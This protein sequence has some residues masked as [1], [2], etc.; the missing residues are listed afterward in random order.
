M[1]LAFE[2]EFIWFSVF[3]LLIIGYC[4]LDGFDL[5]VGMLHLF[6]S[7]DHERRLMLNSIGPVWD[8]NEVWLVTAGG[9]LL[10]GF[11]DVYATVFSAFYL[12]LMALLAALIFRA[13]AIEFRSKQPMAW[14]R[15][16]WDIL[17]SIGSFLIALIL[18]VAIGNLIRGIPLDPHKEFI[19]TLSDLFSPYALLTGV[20]AVALFLMHGAIYLMLKTEGEFHEKMRRFVNPTIIFFI[21][22]YAIATVATL[23][24]MPHM[25]ATIKDRPI[26]FLVALINMFAIANI[27]REIYHGND[28]RAFISSCI[29]IVCLLALFGIGTYPNVVRAIND[30]ENLSL[31]IWNSASSVKTLE[32]LL[33]IA[34]IGI[35]MVV[36]YTVSIYWIFRGKVKL[37]ATSY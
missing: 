35:P 31:H 37:D 1:T 9:A 15:W 19:G 20:T 21:M 34:I 25:T 32:I 29:N 22:C 12:P 4:I 7:K 36:T 26:F 24:Y 5:G 13:V 18:G 3:V 23:I 11:P 28:G 17:F 2:L 14:W 33:L 6:S 16:V 30:P 27:P 10:A 8:G